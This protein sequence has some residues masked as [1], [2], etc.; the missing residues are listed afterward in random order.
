MSGFGRNSILAMGISCYCAI[1]MRCFLGSASSFMQVSNLF[2]F[3][4]CTVL[5]PM[6]L[7]YWLFAAPSLRSV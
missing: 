3:V 6:M 7:E 1:H 5:V 2:F 4:I